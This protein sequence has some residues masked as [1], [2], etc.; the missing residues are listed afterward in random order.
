[1]NICDI[2]IHE[3]NSLKQAASLMEQFGDQARLL[4]GGTDLLVDLKA[5]R[6]Q[7]DHV[8]SISRI[9]ALRGLTTDDAGLSIGALTTANELMQ[10]PA[11]RERLPAIIDAT[12]DLAAPQIRNMATV[13]GNVASAI[14][15]ADLPPILIALDASAVLWSPGGERTVPLA[16]FFAGPRRNICNNDELLKSVV[17]PFP[18]ADSGAAYARFSLRAANACAVA[19]VAAYVQ[20]GDDNVVRD[21]RVV[22]GAVAPTPRLVPQV[23]DVL[24]GQPLDDQRMIA[25]AAAAVAASDPISDIRGS[26]DY[27]RQLVDVLTRRALA[28]SAQRA[29]ESIR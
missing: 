20:I 27:R 18:P 4:A 16:S 24:I 14:P 21:A 6:V 26:A 17:V 9:D 19:G 23:S 22:L 1:M 7:A 15:S 2:Q 29:K 13:G 5:G 3:A 12:Q 25:A 11:V 10:C 8:I 28:T